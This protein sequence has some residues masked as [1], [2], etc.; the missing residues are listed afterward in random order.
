MNILLTKKLAQ[1]Q[2]DLIQSWGWSYE[3]IETLKI[4]PIEVNEIPAK[5]EAW[6]VSSRNSFAAV[7]KFIA[8]APGLIYCVGAW[9]KNEI[10]KLEVKV[11]VKSFENMRAVAADLSKQNFHHVLYF[12]GEEHRQELEEGLKN[13]NIK[14]TKVITYQSEM[15]FPVTKKSFDAVFVFSPRS[16]E[17]LLK[18]NQFSGQTVFAC[19]GSTTRDYVSSRGIKNTFVPSYPDSK[20]L[21]EE[22]YNKLNF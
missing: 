5:T 3:I 18:H 17:S 4:T 22:F 7:E 14:I 19:I 21:L 10:E 8:Q 1:D 13:T 2:L 16:V 9:V 15:I 6:I 20:K 12:C 11:A